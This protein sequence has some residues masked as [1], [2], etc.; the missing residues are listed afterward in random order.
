MFTEPPPLHITR[1]GFAPS[2]LGFRPD[3]EIGAVTDTVERTSVREECIR[4]LEACRRTSEECFA[5]LLRDASAYTRW[6]AV[7]AL[8]DCID[9]CSLTAGLLA[10][11]SVYSEP[12]L[13]LC[14]AVC[15]ACA[16]YCGQSTDP[17]CQACARACQH[18]A[19]TCRLLYHG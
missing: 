6:Y 9:V 11:H 18:C 4:A 3:Y 17:A 1:A 12:M 7:Q 15:E 8:R 5:A 19:R 16:S 14:A 10:R 13:R 2:W